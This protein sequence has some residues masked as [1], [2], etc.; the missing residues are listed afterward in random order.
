MKQRRFNGIHMLVSALAGVLATL[1]VLALVLG[2]QSLSLVTAWGAVRTRFVGDYDPDKALD[3][4][5]EGLVY[6]LDDRWSYY[7]NAGDSARHREQEDNR[8]VGVGVTVTYSDPRG[9]LIQQVYP[10]GP[11]EQAGLKVGEV[12]TAVN[13]AST[14]GEENRQAAL[15]A[16]KGEA[17]T[18]VALTV[19]GENGQTRE[20][21]VT[22]AAVEGRLVNYELLES[23]VG[24]IAVSHFYTGCNRQFRSAVDDLVGQGATALVFDMRNNGG[25]YVRELT[26]MLDY[27][28]PEGPIFR[29]RDVMGVEEV[30]QSDENYVNLPMATL[31]NEDTY[32]AAEIFAAQLQ[33]SAGAYI[34]GAETSGKGYSQQTVSLPN[35]GELHLST[36]KYTTGAGVSLVGAGVTLDAEVELTGEARQ[37]LNAGQL[38]HADDPQL[39]KALELLK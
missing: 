25:G 29:S 23:G 18:E 33:E 11:A 1:L 37:A 13:G 24:Y 38:A 8:Y 4:A 16:I 35:G 21:A 31:V 34:V 19:L 7:L 14:V 15:D 30:V 39:Q 3:S 36:A 32:S 10:G 17:G 28:L 12:I 9:L 27:L 26:D 5:L 20:V 6:G 2:P 22:R